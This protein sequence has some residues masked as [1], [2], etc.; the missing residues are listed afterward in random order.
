MCTGPSRALRPS[1]CVHVATRQSNG[2]TRV[3]W[4]AVRSATPAPVLPLPT[5]LPGAGPQRCIS[6]TAGHRLP[7][8]RRRDRNAA[9]LKPNLD[10]DSPAK[11]GGRLGRKG[12]GREVDG[13]PA[14]R[15]RPR[16]PCRQ[17][18]P[19]CT[20][21]AHEGTLAAIAF[22]SSGSRLASAS[23]KVSAARGRVLGGPP[24]PGVRRAPGA[25]ELLGGTV[26]PALGTHF[27]GRPSTPSVPPHLSSPQTQG[28]RV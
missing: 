21:A 23:E 27:R 2:V 5:E 17:Q 11:G 28:L 25:K 24:L 1:P 6:P 26:A 22:N 7:K 12:E 18:K 4:A 13:T 15:H 20:I 3:L 10:P 8:G 14:P 9:A 16:R 19:V